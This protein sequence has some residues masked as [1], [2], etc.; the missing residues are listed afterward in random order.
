M[1]PR[2][3]RNYDDIQGQLRNGII[4][5]VADP[6]AV[7][8]E[9]VHCLPHHVVVRQDKQTTKVCVVYDTFAKSEGFSLNKCLHIG[10]M[11]NHKIFGNL[12]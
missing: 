1:K 2:L 6:E 11:F 12:A 10:P 3:L 7:S 9:R 4:E 5:P 8:N